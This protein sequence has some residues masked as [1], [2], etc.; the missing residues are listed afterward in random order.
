MDNISEEVRRSGKSTRLADQYIQDLF[1]NGEVEVID[2]TGNKESSEFLFK[3]VVRRLEL[4]H[5]HVNLKL[6]P[7]KGI[8]KLVLNELK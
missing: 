3:K 5:R 2:H 8:I 6:I 1:N 7:K 4:E